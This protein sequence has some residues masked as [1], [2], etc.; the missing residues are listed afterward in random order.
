MSPILDLQQRMMEKGRI[1]LGTK[2][3]T[4]SGKSRPAKLDTFRLTSQDR[5]AI[6][7]GADLWG[8]TVEPFE[9]GGWAVTTTTSAVDVILV[10]GE[11]GWSQWREMWGNKVCHRRCDGVRETISDGPCLCP[12]D[13]VERAAAAA[14]GKAC[15]DTTRLSVMLPD[16]PGLGL[17]RLETHGFYAATELAG[18]IALLSML[19]PGTLVRGRL[20]AQQREVVRFDRDGKP[21]TNKF[22]VPVLDLPDV[23]LS[24]L[25]APDGGVGVSIEA[26]TRRGLTPVPVAELPEGPRPSIVEQIATVPDQPKRRSNAAAPLPATGLKPRKMSGGGDSPSPPVAVAAPGLPAPDPEA[27]SLSPEVEPVPDTAGD[28]VGS[29]PAG[30]P[31]A[32]GGQD[33]PPPL[34]A[35]NARA[36]GALYRKCRAIH[37]EHGAGDKETAG[38][39]WDALAFAVSAGRSVH[40]GELSPDEA[41]D[42]RARMIDVSE[43]RSRWAETDDP[44]FLGWTL[45]TVEAS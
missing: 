8:G 44:Q 24:E 30:V 15:K 38:A 26:P 3:P 29:A 25:V 35:V 22:V 14:Q 27:P 31:S 2:A 39:Q 41:T 33:S 9:P 23:R 40:L 7:A 1:R 37:A 18:T 34:K 36:Y 21:R 45:T 6:D 5:A 4:S 28:E 17:W 13:H 19:A 32:P 12:A 43:G 16:L 11:M 20:V 42:F 10:P